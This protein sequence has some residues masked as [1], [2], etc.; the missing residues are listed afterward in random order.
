MSSEPKQPDFFQDLKRELKEVWQ[1]TQFGWEQTKVAFHNTTRRLRAA[2]FEYVVLRVG[3]SLPERREP[4]RSFIE[5]QLPL[6]PPAYS[7][8]SFAADMRLIAEAQNVQGVILVLR[9]FATGLA[10]LQSVRQSMQ[11]VQAAGKQVVV[12]SHT[13]DL[14]HFFVATAADKIFAPP[15]AMFDVLGLRSEAIFLKDALDMVGVHV[16]AV[17]I[18]PYKTGVNPL[19]KS[20]MTPEQAEQ[21]NW[22][23][24]DTYDWLTAVMAEGRNLSQSQMHE[25]IDQAPMFAE[26]ALAAGLIDGVAYED[27]L[28]YLLAKPAA[29]AT[30]AEDDRQDTAEIKETAETTATAVSPTD[31]AVAPSP[32]NRPK[33]KIT[34]YAHAVDDFIY[35]PVRYSQKFIGVISITGAIMPGSSQNPP[36]DLPIPLVGEETA[37]EATLVPLFR[38]AEQLDDMAALIVH[39]DSP[40]GSALASD[41]IAREIARL[42]NKKPVLI[43]MGDVAASGG[44]YVSARS[45][46]IMCQPLTLTGSIGVFITRLST[47]GFFHKVKV[48]RTEVTRGKRATLYSDLAPLNEEELT[49]LWDG[50]VESY[51]QFK[52]VVANGRNL[53]YEEL[54]AICEGRVWTGR[55]ALAHGLVDSFGDF[56]DA[57]YKAAELAQMEVGPNTYIRTIN[58]YPKGD[59]YRLPKPFAEAEELIKALTGSRLQAMHN[60]PMMLL[61]YRIRFW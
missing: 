55:Q 57:I 3:G 40:G 47:D 20:E 18:S 39:V 2:D 54:D 38:R 46:H 33:A 12:F 10:T 15:S 42:N 22:L 16:D 50:V 41:L 36:I 56:T 24:D 9:G 59:G 27:E 28:A 49:V 34:K 14:P 61:P 7:M 4:P 25:L 29:E 31:T 1:E 45:R 13:L 23:L 17:Q 26:Q 44:Y 37:G 6:P 32:N 51:R 48:N 43:Y 11:R 52:Q 8:Q 35:K 5:R 19:S 53:P 58:L 30:P 21:L 60:K